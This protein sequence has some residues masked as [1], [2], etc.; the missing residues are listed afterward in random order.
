MQCISLL[1]PTRIMLCRLHEAIKGGEYEFIV[2]NQDTSRGLDF[3][4]INVC[5]CSVA[6]A[7]VCVCVCV[8]LS[9]Q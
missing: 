8:C 1:T 4:G 6:C 7:C 9:M 2:T 3:D 5:I